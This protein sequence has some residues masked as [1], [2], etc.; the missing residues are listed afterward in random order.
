MG[1]LVLRDKLRWNADDPSQTGTA[2]AWFDEW[3]DAG[4]TAALPDGTPVDEFD[5]DADEIIMSVQ[6]PPVEG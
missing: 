1:V 3:K 6:V 2:A 4:C 5:P